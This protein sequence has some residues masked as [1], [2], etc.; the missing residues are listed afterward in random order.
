MAELL[1]KAKKIYAALDDFRRINWVPHWDLPWLSPRQ[2]LADGHLA[3]QRG[4]VSR[5]GRP[6]LVGGAA[7]RE[8]LAVVIGIE[9]I[10][11]AELADRY[12]C[13]RRPRALLSIL[14]RKR[15]TDAK[16]FLHPIWNTNLMKCAAL[17]GLRENRPIPN[18]LQICGLN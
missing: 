12:S 18:R 7:S 2:Q 8:Q 13:C 1:L 5:R 15:V 6:P 14:S 4:C 9:R 11:E 3:S 10:N 16:R 17:K